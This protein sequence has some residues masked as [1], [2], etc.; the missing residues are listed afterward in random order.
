[1]KINFIILYIILGIIIYFS[2]LYIFNKK[3]E[4]NKKNENNEI[5]YNTSHITELKNK[6][7]RIVMERF[8]LLNKMDFKEW[9]NY[10]QQNSKIKI[11]GFEYNIFL[12][13]KINNNFINTVASSQDLQM[14]SW[15][16]T[17]SYGDIYRYLTK[18]KT[19]DN[20][21]LNMYHLSQKSPNEIQYF[22]VDYKTALPSKRVAIFK[23][24][25]KDGYEGIIGIP[26]TVEDKLTEMG[27][28]KN[29]S[30]L[31]NFFYLLSFILVFL[32]GLL[33]L[34]LKTDKNIIPI[35]SFTILITLSIYLIYFFNIKTMENDPKI[36]NDRI[37]IIARNV[38]AIA[39]LTGVNIFI[40]NSFKTSKNIIFFKKYLIIFIFSIL[41]LL[42]SIFSKP[43]INTIRDILNIRLRNELFFNLCILYNIII[44]I[45]YIFGSVY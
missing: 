29:Y 21:I 1:M 28:K 3:T 27:T 17:K 7:T 42:L 19:D 44:L 32:S 9:I 10:N 20:L 14:L 16:D 13:Q 25:N 26:F 31:G 4:E 5:D 38:S 23:A 39:F 15:N 12:F 2:G 45:L 34:F 18:Y 8:N 22:W 11:N 6:F 30:F 43:D 40:I 33:I 37:N 41:S 24:F 36:E 35:T